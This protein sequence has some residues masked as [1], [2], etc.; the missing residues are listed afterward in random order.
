M[1]TKTVSGLAIVCSLAML[2]TGCGKDSPIKEQTAKAE[3]N[4]ILTEEDY[5]GVS[6]EIDYIKPTPKE[7]KEE[8][9]Y[10]KPA[11]TPNRVAQGLE[12]QNANDIEVVVNKKNKLP[13]N[14]KPKDLV[15][16]NV[17]FAYDGVYEKSHLRKEASDSLEKLFALAEKDGIYLNAVSGFRSAEY[18]TKVY[19]GNVKKDGKDHADMFSAKPGHSE[20]Q[21][22]LVMDVSA[23]S[24]DNKLEQEFEQTKEGKWLAKNAHKTGFIIRY[25]KGKEDVTGYEYEPWHIRYVGDIATNLFEKGLTLEEYKEQKATYE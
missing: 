20:H 9:D 10:I 7:N 4:E 8:V 6:E 22:G 15:V 2:T 23:K 21:T 18:Q 5:L 16:P 24:F 17:S 11:T 12:R 25:P 13:D 14:Y 3:V 19:N 1:K